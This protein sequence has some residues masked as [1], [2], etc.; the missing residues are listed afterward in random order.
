MFFGGGANSYFPENFDVIAVVIRA[1]IKAT[2]IGTTNSKGGDN[3]FCDNGKELDLS[4]LE[5]ISILNRNY[6]DDFPVV[7]ISEKSF[8]FN[9]KAASLLDAAY[10]RLSKAGPYFIFRPALSSGVAYK[11]YPYR[12]GGMY[13]SAGKAVSLCGARPRGAYRL[14]AVKGGGYAININEPLDRL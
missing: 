13:L 12:T 11:P 14:Q 9:K 10:I 7:S 1:V 6:G 4:E 5:E 8:Y 3:L 2:K